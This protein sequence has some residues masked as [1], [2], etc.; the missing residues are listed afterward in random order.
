MKVHKFVCLV[1]EKNHTKLV[2]LL[3]KGMKINEN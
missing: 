2:L 3:M 1:E